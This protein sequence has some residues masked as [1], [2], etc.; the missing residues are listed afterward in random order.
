LHYGNS[1]GGTCS[2]KTSFCSLLFSIWSSFL[3]LSLFKFL[4][5]NL[6]QRS[7]RGLLTA[8]LNPLF[9]FFFFV[10]LWQFWRGAL[11]AI[12]PL[13]VLFFFHLIFFSPSLFILIW[14]FGRGS[15]IAVPDLLLSSVHLLLFFK[16]W[17]FWRGSLIA[18]FIQLLFS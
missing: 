11:V 18:V 5:Y 17:Q 9:F 12:E 4:Q 3:H 13:L 6:I 15:L 1:G 2:H 7:T 10:V 14:Q 8:V 16:L